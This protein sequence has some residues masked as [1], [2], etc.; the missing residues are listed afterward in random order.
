MRAGVKNQDSNIYYVICDDNPDWFR[1]VYIRFNPWTGTEQVSVSNPIAGVPTPEMKPISP[2]KL[3]RL[4]RNQ[5]AST[6]AG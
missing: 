3:Q 1:S 5:M 4:M 2:L 6:Y